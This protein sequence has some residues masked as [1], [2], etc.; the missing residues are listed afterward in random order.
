[1]V[2]SALTDHMSTAEIILTVFLAL[3]VLVLLVLV[4]R[5]LWR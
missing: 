5:D 3:A 4:V 1:M 2:S